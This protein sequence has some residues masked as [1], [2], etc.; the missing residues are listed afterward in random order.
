MNELKMFL[1]QHPHLMSYQIRLEKEMNSVPDADR[2]KVLAKHIIYNLQE[3]E[4]ELKLLQL[5]LT[6]I[7]D[8]NEGNT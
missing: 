1:E 7:G 8:T 4:I 6:I 2:L 3:L 5:K